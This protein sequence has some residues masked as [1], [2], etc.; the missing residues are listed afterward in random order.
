MRATF[1]AARDEAGARAREFFQRLHNVAALGFSGVSGGAN[2]H[3][4]VVHDGIALEGETIGH[5]FFFGLLVM[6]KQHIGV[7]TA[8]HVERLPSAQGDHFDVEPAGFFE[9]W[10]QVGKQA[11]LLGRRG[12][13]HHQALRLHPA[14][15]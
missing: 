3:K 12:G 4:V 10:Q 7:A 8:S 13:R 14:T 6:H 15:G 2:Q 5:H 11:R 9:R 1:V